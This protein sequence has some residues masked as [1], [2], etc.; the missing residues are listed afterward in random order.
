M[1]GENNTLIIDG[2]QSP[3]NGS[4]PKAIKKEL[5]NQWK[6]RVVSNVELKGAFNCENLEYVV[7]ALSVF[8]SIGHLTWD[9]ENLIEGNALSPFRITESLAE[10]ETVKS[11]TFL[12]HNLSFTDP[13]DEDETIKI[14]C[15][16]FIKAFPY[17][18]GLEKITIA[19]APDTMSKDDCLQLR[20]SLDTKNR[21]C[22]ELSQVFFKNI[23]RSSSFLDNLYAAMDPKN[24]SS[25]WPSTT[26]E[27]DNITHPFEFKQSSSE[28]LMKFIELVKKHMKTAESKYGPHNVFF[29]F[30]Q[31]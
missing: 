31:L 23:S 1:P 11:I 4:N 8:Q 9:V 10:N 29:K 28:E 7:S 15:E 24:L 19:Q 17:M 25:L 21:K 5:V 26:L 22:I 18:K 13:Y 20:T 27:I 16:H 2:S 12:R 3:Y 14:Q 6:G 30:K